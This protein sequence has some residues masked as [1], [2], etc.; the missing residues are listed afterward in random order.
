MLNDIQICTNESRNQ[1]IKLRTLNLSL[2]G[3]E[4]IASHN[5]KAPLGAIN[6]EIKNITSGL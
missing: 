4:P 3:R 1:I 2:P 6:I 5:N